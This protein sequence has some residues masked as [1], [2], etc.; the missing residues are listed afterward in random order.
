MRN[1]A[2][3]SFKADNMSRKSGFKN[4]L[5]FESPSVQSQ[6]PHHLDALGNRRVFQ[7]ILGALGCE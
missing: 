6:L 5:S 4:R 2:P 7:V 3:A 1:S